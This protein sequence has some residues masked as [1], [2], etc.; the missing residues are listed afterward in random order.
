MSEN[1]NHVELAKETLKMFE[2]RGENLNDIRHVIHYFYGGNFTDLAVVMAES[3]YSVR[4]TAN[5]DGVIA[6]LD[7][8][9]VEEWRTSTLLD[10]CL[11]S[12]SCGVEYDGWEASMTRQQGTSIQPESDHWDS[13]LFGKE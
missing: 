8:A 2:D 3:G 7:E 9:I 11:L 6:E 1:M 10:I 4:S 13:G 5:E 12:D